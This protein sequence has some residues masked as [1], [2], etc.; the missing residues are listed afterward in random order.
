MELKHL[1]YFVAAV[2]EGSLQGAALRLH[3]AQPALSRRVRDL[4][5]SLGCELLARG[6]RGITPTHAGL[7]LYKDAIAL[8]ENA[9]AAAQRVRRLGLEQGSK[10]RFGLAHSTPRKYAFLSDALQA[11]A[12]QHPDSGIAF[13][14]ASSPDL[15]AALEAGTID[16]ALLY[17]RRPDVAKVGERLIHHERYVLAAHPAHPLGKTGP[18]DLAS[19]AGHPLVWLARRDMPEN[20]NP[21]MLQLKR[22]GLVPVI[23]QLADSPDEQIDLTIA[24]IGLCIT[25][26]STILMIPQGTLLFR[27]IPA[28]AME[29]DVSLG[30]R[31]D[32][33]S[34]AA[35]ALKMHLHAAIERH[36]AAIA[37]GEAQW[38]RLDGNLLFPFP[39]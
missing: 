25:P 8:L 4:E 32:A 24:R 12:E 30:W 17:E 11:F 36:R 9:T 38:A 10:I 22:H 35:G 21:L 39:P 29:L 33:A 37:S 27:S 18:V 13:I 15:L 7:A 19:L 26:A 20:L 6:P 34:P 16:L 23:G 2:E 5:V 28:L 1:R 31:R 3:M 14:R